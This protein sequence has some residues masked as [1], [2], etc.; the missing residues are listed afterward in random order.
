[1]SFGA[2]SPQWKIDV[3]VWLDWMGGG[4]AKMSNANELPVVEIME[5]AEEEEG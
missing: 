2:V 4:T 3:I 1:M 5:K